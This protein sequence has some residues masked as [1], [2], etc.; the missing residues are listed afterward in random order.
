MSWLIKLGEKLEN[1]IALIPINNT[2]EARKEKDE[3]MAENAIREEQKNNLKV[4]IKRLDSIKE[5]DNFFIGDD[6]TTR[7]TTRY[8]KKSMELR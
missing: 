3:F 4:M 5:G 7:Q 1:L 8:K 6:G 2:E